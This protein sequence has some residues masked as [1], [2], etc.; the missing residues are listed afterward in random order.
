MKSHTQEHELEQIH[1]RTNRAKPVIGGFLVGSVIGV[2]TALLFAPR[3][4]EETR[5]EIRDRAVDLRDRTTDTVNQTVSQA[6][7]KA[8]EIKDTVQQKAQEV[9]E[10]GRQKLTKQLD[11]ASEA[12]DNGKKTASDY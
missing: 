2:A 8:Y 12:L 10:R 7:S 5:A 6:K 9:T 11:R 1:H 3:S 4:G